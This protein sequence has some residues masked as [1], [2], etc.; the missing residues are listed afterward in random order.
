MFPNDDSKA[1]NRQSEC[2]RFKHLHSSPWRETVIYWLY[3]YTCKAVSYSAE[4]SHAAFSFENKTLSSKNFWSALW[5]VCIQLCKP[6]YHTR[7]GKIIYSHPSSWPDFLRIAEANS[8][9]KDNKRSLIRTGCDAS[10]RAAVATIKTVLGFSPLNEAHHT[11][12]HLGE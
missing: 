2:F 1:C 6:C 8:F 9:S 4:N 11:V 10:Q 7:V 3:W 5:E 12:Y